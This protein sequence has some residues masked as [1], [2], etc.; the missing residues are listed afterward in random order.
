MGNPLR[1]GL[2]VWAVTPDRFQDTVLAVAVAAAI[3][4]EVAVMFLQEPADP[5]L[6]P[7]PEIQGLL[8]HQECDRETDRSPSVGKNTLV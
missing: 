3:M 6:Y 2:W 1:A 4:V 8:Q 7:T 5:A